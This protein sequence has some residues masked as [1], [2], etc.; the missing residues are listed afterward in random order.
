MYNTGART[1]K[2]NAVPRFTVACDFLIFADILR[3]LLHTHMGNLH[4][5][6]RASKTNFDWPFC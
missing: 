4:T 2:L 6:E 3:M 5:E 1:F